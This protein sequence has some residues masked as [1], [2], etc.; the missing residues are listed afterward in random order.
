MQRRCCRR[1]SRRAWG[2][3]EVWSR[4]VRRGMQCSES[5]GVRERE[6]ERQRGSRILS[7]RFELLLLLLLHDGRRRPSCTTV[8]GWCGIGS[9]LTGSAHFC[10]A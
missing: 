2:A 4:S 3:G 9:A 7:G 6:R 8:K 1:D 5:A 10:F